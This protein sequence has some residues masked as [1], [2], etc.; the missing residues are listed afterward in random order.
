[1][2]FEFLILKWY[3][4]LIVVGSLAAIIQVV[5]YFKDKKFDKPHITLR[6]G[7]GYVYLYCILQTNLIPMITLKKIMIKKN[8]FI[9][10]NRIFAETHPNNVAHSYALANGKNQI[11]MIIK[12]YRGFYIYLKEEDS[13]KKLN[14]IFYTDTGKIKLKYFPNKK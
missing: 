4:Y 9:K 2:S 11:P 12:D 13:E 14:I 6:N 1:M 3:E 7:Q 10:Q 8:L 5:R